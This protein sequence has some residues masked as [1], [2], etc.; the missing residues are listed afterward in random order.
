[1]GRN[2]R[3]PL[4]APPVLLAL[5][6]PVVAFQEMPEPPPQK[7]ASAL[8]PSSDCS[9]SKTKGTRPSSGPEKVFNF[10]IAPRLDLGLE[11]LYGNKQQGEGQDAI[12]DETGEVTVLGK[13][14]RRF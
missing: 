6:G 5:S 14:K 3:I 2:W 9:T 13:V 7:G 11:L 10:D 4:A 8:Q 12:A 1:M